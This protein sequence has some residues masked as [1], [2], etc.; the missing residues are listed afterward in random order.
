LERQFLHARRLSFEHPVTGERITL[1]SELP[2]DL[3]VV[4]ERLRLGR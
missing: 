1:E 2:E 3:R 4:L